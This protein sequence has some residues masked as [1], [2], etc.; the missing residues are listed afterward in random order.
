[1]AREI[2]HTYSVMQGDYMENDI[3][4]VLSRCDKCRKARNIKTF[5]RLERDDKNG[6]FRAN[7]ELV[8]KNRYLLKDI[9]IL[10]E[11]VSGMETNKIIKEIVNR[12][13]EEK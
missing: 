2:L 11:F 4:E 13:K 6:F 3:N 9:R 1:M 5:M 10:C 8:D 7:V 12:Y